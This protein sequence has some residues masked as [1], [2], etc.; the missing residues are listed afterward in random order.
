MEK[1]TPCGQKW[2]NWNERVSKGIQLCEIFFAVL[3]QFL[4]ETA[5]YAKLSRRF[6]GFKTK[7]PGPIASKFGTNMQINNLKLLSKFHVARPN[8]S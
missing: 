5:F 2:V 6:L 3:E 7:V 4:N 8:R 1:K